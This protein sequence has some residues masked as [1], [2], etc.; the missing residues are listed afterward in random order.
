MLIF[1]HIGARQDSYEVVLLLLARGAK[2]DS[3]NLNGD[4]PLDCCPNEGSDCWT[5]INMN[6]Q[7]QAL[8]ANTQERT[9]RILSK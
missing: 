1:S 4:R 9:Q 8:L 3:K 2:V 6:V 7:L 5:A